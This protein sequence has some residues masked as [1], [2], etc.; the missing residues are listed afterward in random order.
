V[1]C[2]ASDQ[3]GSSGGG[4]FK[5]RDVLWIRQLS[6]ERNSAYGFCDGTN[7]FHHLSDIDGD[8]VEPGAT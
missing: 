1:A 2:I 4:N 5:K 7:P 3:D 8:K 6:R